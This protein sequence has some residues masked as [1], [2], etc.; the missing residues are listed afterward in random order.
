MT[1][2]LIFQIDHICSSF[3]FF[4]ESFNS[5]RKSH[6]VQFTC[7]ESLVIGRHALVCLCL[8]KFHTWHRVNK[9]H[10]NGHFLIATHTVE[11][12]YVWDRVLTGGKVHR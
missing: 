4:E 10:G 1:S 8:Y 9:E 7:K 11:Q 12:S 2:A 3:T 5:R 6:T